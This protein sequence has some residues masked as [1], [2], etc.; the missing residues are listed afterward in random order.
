MQITLVETR[1][2]EVNF[3]AED[4]PGQP[5]ETEGGEPKANPYKL[6]FQ[7]VKNIDNPKEFGI[8]F[9]CEVKVTGL[10]SMKVVYLARFQTTE[11]LT[12][13]FMAGHFVG[14]NAP[15]ISYPYLRAFISQVLLLSGYPPIT[16]PTINFQDMFKDEQAKK[17]ALQE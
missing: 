17:A 6:G 7:R 1:A 12:E 14:M 5:S 15:A 4:L 2:L 8:F 9:T 13:A 3:I 10:R 11:E 16:L